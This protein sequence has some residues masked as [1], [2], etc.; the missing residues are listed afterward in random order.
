MNNATAAAVN[1][2]V[3]VIITVVS[4]FYVIVL[5]WKKITDE[6]WIV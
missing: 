2:T 1:A 6:T 3:T 4:V 5:A